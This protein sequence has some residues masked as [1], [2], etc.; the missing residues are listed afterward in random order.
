MILRGIHI[1]H[2][3]CIERLDLDDLPAGIVVLHGPN[4]T[5]K[6]SIVKA[7]RGCLFDFDH[8]SAKAEI[9]SSLPWNGAGP[10]RLCVEFET[11]GLLY[12]ITKVMARRQ[13]GARLEC[14]HNGQW[15]LLEDSPKE[16]SRRTRELLGSDR[17]TSGLQQLLWLD[18]GQTNLPASSID[19][20]LEERLINVLGVMVTGRDLAFQEALAAR[21][22]RWFGVSG[23]HKPSSPCSKLQ[24]ARDEQTA[25]LQE[26]EQQYA[27]LDD[28]ITQLA[29][30]EARQKELV[31]E[32]AHLQ[33][34]VDDLHAERER[35]RERLQLF[36]TAE[37]ECRRL[38][39]H[40]QASEQRLRGY[41]Q[42]HERW[43]Q[44]EQAAV[45]LEGAEQ[46]AAEEC[47]QQAA[48]CAEAAQALSQAR[49]AEDRQRDQLQALDQARQILALDQRRRR[50]EETLRRGD[51]VR[52][53][54]RE[55]EEQIRRLPA[56]DRGTLEALAAN[57]REAERLRA[58]LQAASLALR[59]EVERAAEF[60]VEID[61]QPARAVEL[62]A[63]A[64][65][66]AAPRQ[67]ARVDI[68][69]WG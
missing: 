2:W 7:L 1:D 41:Q 15:Q 11:G 29:G 14:R 9:R 36:Q 17:S 23:K 37:A 68:P 51:E 46:A 32:V 49:Q 24:K 18:Q 8:D 42:A 47:Q 56:I 69:G 48:A 62:A 13:G 4:R 58:R 44:A 67:Q 52:G 55:L 64:D 21:H 5:G 26:I 65:F 33:S 12:R 53:E 39:Q 57:R 22:D 38:E 66:H 40:R 30:H 63:G 60:S 61:D 31:D 6:S 19:T 3:R 35:V 50:L 59:V 54:C 28:V 45:R 27:A 10:P 43:K 25:A 16:A 34:T 20:S